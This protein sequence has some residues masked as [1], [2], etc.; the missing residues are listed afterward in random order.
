M[1]VVYEL[2]A[3][4]YHAHSGLRIMARRILWGSLGIGAGVALLCAPIVLTAVWGCRAFQCRLFAILEIKRFFETGLITFAPILLVRLSRLPV[5]VT[6]NS[7]VHAACFN[8]YLLTSVVTG[9]ITFVDRHE[10][11]RLICNICLMVADILCFS[12]WFIGMRRSQ[13]A[14]PPVYPAQEVANLTRRI[15]ELTE[16]CKLVVTRVR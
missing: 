1:L 11:P 7:R 15:R 4:I 2:F 12:G 9:I 13:E 10:E 14:S 16:V 3:E 6:R 8:L 5:T